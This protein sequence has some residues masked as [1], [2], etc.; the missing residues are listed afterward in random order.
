MRSTPFLFLIAAAGLT[1]ACSSG[2]SSA[3]D[4]FAQRGA[5]GSNQASVTVA[6][7]GATLLI[8]HS[9]S[10]C[11][12]SYGDIAQM[13]PTGSFTIPGV[14]TQLTGVAPGRVQYAAQFSG[15]VAGNQMAITVSVPALQ[16]TFGPFNLTYGVSN[17]WVACMFP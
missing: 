1:V 3:S 14:Y 8:L 9:G 17:T 10:S 7:S 2:S 16:Q 13:V 6:A 5:W 4:D 12:G 15:T 11:Y